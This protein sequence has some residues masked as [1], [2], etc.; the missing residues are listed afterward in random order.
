MHT[1]RTTFSLYLFIFLFAALSAT[2]QDIRLHTPYTRVSV[3][4]GESVRYTLKARNTGDEVRTADLYMRGL[5]RTW[6]HEL[7]AGGYELEQIS[8]L[9]GDSETM[10]LNVTVP[11]RVNKGAQ[12]FSLVAAGHDTLQLVINVSEKGTY[13]SEFTASQSNLQGHADADF[14]FSAK[15]ENRTG[16]KQS[17]ALTA[18]PPR[19]WKVTFK[20][21][22]KQATAVEVEPNSTANINIE[23]DPPVNVD[24]GTFS[25]P[26]VASNR[27]T[28]AG[29]DLEVVI[30]AS[31]D[32][33]L[34]TP[35]GLL[36]SKLQAGRGKQLDLVVK[37]TGSGDLENIRLSANDPARW[38]L[39]IEPDTIRVLKPGTTANI[40]ATVTPYEKS[41]PGDYVARITARTDEVSSTA[42][43]R[44]SVKTSLLWGWVGVIV[45]VGI[46]L[47]IWMLF[48]KYGRR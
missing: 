46:I 48:R 47:A 43:F 28:S 15:L 25:I 8:I 19:G 42:A 10:T 2:A 41:I 7:K 29:L 26:V 11:R 3:P 17:Y 13:V 20:P 14:T 4:P 9:P 18:S 16:E 30:T 12:R 44:L 35:D 38:E 1:S 45:I 22:Y 5:P 36:S 6:T 39:S 27:S 21:N 31:Y 37:N 34:T 23:V 24:A 32:I 40:K 33:E